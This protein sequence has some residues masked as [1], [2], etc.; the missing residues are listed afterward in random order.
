MKV[1][2]SLKFTGSM[3]NAYGS[4]LFRQKD[5]LSLSRHL[6]F[7]LKLN[8]F[9]LLSFCF[10]HFLFLKKKFSYLSCFTHLL[11]GKL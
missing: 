2:R 5:S 9:L 10:F 8:S 1:D 6:T 11:N 7:A 4:E 3:M